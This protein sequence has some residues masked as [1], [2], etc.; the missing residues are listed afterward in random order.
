M[1]IRLWSHV[2]MYVCQW[3]CMNARLMLA[4]LN[5]CTSRYLSESTST[6]RGLACLRCVNKSRICMSTCMHH[7]MYVTC[8]CMPLYVYNTPISV[9]RMSTNMRYACIFVC[10]CTQQRVTCTHACIYV[11]NLCMY[12]HTYVTMYVICVCSQDMSA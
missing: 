5:V 2:I 6:C 7:Y 3:A 4:C 8:A 9:C 11:C 12:L 10:M 1:P